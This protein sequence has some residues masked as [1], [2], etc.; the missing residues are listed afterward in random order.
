MKLR[1]AFCVALSAF[2]S[3]GMAQSFIC[4]TDA[5][6][7]F[8][9]NKT[10]S[11][12]EPT[13][14]QSEHKFVFTPS[15]FGIYKF[16]VKNLGESTP[17]AFCENEFSDNGSISC[18]GLGQDFKLSSKS[19][20]FLRTYQSGYWNEDAIKALLP[21]RKEGDDTPAMSIGKCSPIN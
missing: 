9:F 15:K 11:A 21:S 16:E 3:I 8:I 20:R 5:A 14:F 1:T 13:Q 18:R 19:L 7:G 4:S 10:S 2:H 17:F 12:W 6:T